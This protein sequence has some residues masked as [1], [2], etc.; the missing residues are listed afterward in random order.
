[1]GRCE[2]QRGSQ[3]EGI[4]KHHIICYPSDAVV[5]EFEWM[6]RSGSTIIILS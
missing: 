3:E 1:M 4:A 5:W 2:G 6:I